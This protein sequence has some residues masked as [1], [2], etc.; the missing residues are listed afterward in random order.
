M[1]VQSPNPPQLRYCTSIHF[2]QNQ[3]FPALCLPN[4]VS[5]PNLPFPVPICPVSAAAAAGAQAAVLS[6]WQILVHGAA[7]GDEAQAQLKVTGQ[8]TVRSQGQDQQRGDEEETHHQQGHAASV[9]QQVWAVGSRPMRPHL[10][11]AKRTQN[12]YIWWFGSKFVKGKIVVCWECRTPCGSLET[13]LIAN[14]SHWKTWMWWTTRLKNE[15]TKTK[16]VN[17]TQ[18]WLSTILSTIFA[19][20]MLTNMHCM[21][22][23]VVLCSYAGW[24]GDKVKGSQFQSGR[25]VCRQQA[26]IILIAM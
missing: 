4:S 23:R 12:V 6:G 3:C 15:L 25:G 26:W 18:I 14:L 8:A 22:M 5:H 19:L 1:V 16:F 21:P 2:I 10:R 9:G 13:H 7:V 20:K 24:V 17:L 11:G